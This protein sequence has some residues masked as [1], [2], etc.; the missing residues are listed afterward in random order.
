MKKNF[1][2]FDPEMVIKSS[3]QAIEP[4]GL[5]QHNIDKPFGIFRVLQR[6]RLQRLQITD[7]GRSGVRISCVT[8]ATKSVRMRSK[9]FQARHIMKHNHG[10]L[11]IRKSLNFRKAY[12]I[13]TG[14]A[15]PRAISLLISR[16][17]YS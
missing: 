4:P 13:M 9:F 10:L 16:S 12:L 1:A 6:P 5:L 14:S 3:N 8:L 7:N 15:P 2:Q 17:L 11:F